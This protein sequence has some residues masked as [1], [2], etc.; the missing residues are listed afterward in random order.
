MAT[1]FFMVNSSSVARISQWEGVWGF[2]IDITFDHTLYTGDDPES[3][4]GGCN[5]KLS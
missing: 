3:F 1:R 4:A 5:F 2:D